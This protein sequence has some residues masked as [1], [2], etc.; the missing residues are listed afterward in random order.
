[1]HIVDLYSALREDT[2]NVQSSAPE[3]SS[4]EEFS[5]G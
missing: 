3:S 1:M 2:S 5:S 4:L